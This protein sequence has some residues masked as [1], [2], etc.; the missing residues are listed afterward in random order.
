MFLIHTNDLFS[1]PGLGYLM[2]FHDVMNT[3]L[4]GPKVAACSAVFSQ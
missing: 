4:G 2:D 1:V 3:T